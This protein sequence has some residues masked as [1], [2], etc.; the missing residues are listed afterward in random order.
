VIKGSGV[1][2]FL[3]FLVRNGFGACGFFCVCGEVFL[4]EG[5]KKGLWRLY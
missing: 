5:E 3:I 4:R 1:F 2:Y